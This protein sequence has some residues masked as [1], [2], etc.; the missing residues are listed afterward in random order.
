MTEVYQETTSA[1]GRASQNNKSQM[2]KG[3]LE[4]CV[5]LIL[6]RKAA[7]SSDIIAQLKNARLIVVEGTLYPLLSRLKKD[8]LLSY[9]W[10]ESTQGPPR[11]YYV[12]TPEGQLALKDMHAEWAELTATVAHL[13][14]AAR[15]AQTAENDGTPEAT[16]VIEVAPSVAA[17]IEETETSAI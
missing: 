16:N 5:L 13:E 11:K 15:E 6:S 1:R 9:Q 10:Q 7:Y 17:P 3:M 8:G 4:F 14:A 2:R 12:L